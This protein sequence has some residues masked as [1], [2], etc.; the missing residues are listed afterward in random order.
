MPSI[1]RTRGIASGINNAVSRTS[2]LIAIAALGIVLS[3]AFTH[4]VGRAASHAPLSSAARAAMV[5][6][7]AVLLAGNS[8]RCADPERTS[9]RAPH[10][11]RRVRRWVSAHDAH[12][13]RAYAARGGDRFG[14]LFPARPRVAIGG[15]LPER[16]DAVSR[17]LWR[18][19]WKLEPPMRNILMAFARL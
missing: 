11:A 4:S 8:G 5:R 3:L 17:T 16:A 12:Q 2:G 13:H 14:P 10:R 1:P 19:V 6:E 7:S 15:L 9:R 18:L